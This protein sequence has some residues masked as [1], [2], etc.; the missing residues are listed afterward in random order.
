MAK[1]NSQK[2]N[3]RRRPRRAATQITQAVRELTLATQQVLPAQRPDVTRMR[4]NHRQLYTFERTTAVQFNAAGF[5]FVQPTLA[6]LPNSSEFTTLFS[7]YRFLQIVAEIP[8]WNPALGGVFSSA[9]F[10]FDNT[11]PTTEALLT[12]LD[13]Y[14]QHGQQNNTVRTTRTWTPR[15]TQTGTV[16]QTLSNRQWF[17]T[18]DAN[19]EQNGLVL[20]VVAGAATLVEIYLHCIVQFMNPY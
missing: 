10:Y 9:I 19:V 7:K 11:P 12:N 3:Q 4:V 8:P 17:G 20:N 6:S 16:Q 14:V 13:T 2:R 18:G 15:A 5:Q 1:H